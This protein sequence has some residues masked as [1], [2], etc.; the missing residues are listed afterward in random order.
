MLHSAGCHG[1]GGGAVGGG[2]SGERL[3]EEGIHRQDTSQPVYSDGHGEGRAGADKVP[4]WKQAVPGCLC[5][6]PQRFRGMGICSG[7]GE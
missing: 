6:P 1:H 5:V 7:E 3:S 2:L 4:D